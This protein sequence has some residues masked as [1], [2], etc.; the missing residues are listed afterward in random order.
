MDTVANMLTALVNAQ[1]VKKE[2][3]AVPHSQFTQRLLAVLKDHGRIADFRVQEGPQAKV[4]VTLAYR[5]GKQPQLSGM[6]RISS[7]GGRRYVVHTKLPYPKHGEGFYLISTSR[8]VMDEVRARKE[9]LG[10]EL[11]CEIW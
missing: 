5:S 8:G 3:V 7:P 4:V 10:G 9:K 2:R 1:R 11:M 6:R